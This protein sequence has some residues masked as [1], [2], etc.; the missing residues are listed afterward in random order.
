MRGG[1]CELSNL[2]FVDDRFIPTCGGNGVSP[3]KTS[4]ADRFIPTC[5]GV[6]YADTFNTAIDAVHPHVRGGNT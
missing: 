2:L 1:N 4:Q 5:V 3:E 6:T